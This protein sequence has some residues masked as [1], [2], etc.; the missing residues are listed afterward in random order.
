[1]TASP[2]IQM[3][4]LYW[5]GARLYRGISPAAPAVAYPDATV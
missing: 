2:R 1:M 5:S 3:L 4:G